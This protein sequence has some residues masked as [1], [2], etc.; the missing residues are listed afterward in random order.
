MLVVEMEENEINHARSGSPPRFSIIIPAFNSGKTIAKCIRSVLAQSFRDFEVIVVDDGSS[1]ETVRIVS[2]FECV[3]LLEQENAGPGCARNRGIKF[4]D[5]D[6]CIFLDSDD[7]WFPD[8]LSIIHSQIEH[9]KEPGLVI[10]SAILNSGQKDL[11]TLERD[12]LLVVEEYLNYYS[13]ADHAISVVGCCFAVKTAQLRMME[14]PFL[15]EPLNAEDLHLLMRLGLVGGFVWIRKPEVLIYN[16]DSN[17]LMSQ[18]LKTIRGINSLLDHEQRGFYPGG[19]GFRK[20][21]WEILT[22]IARSGSLNA[23][24]S[25]DLRLGWALYHRTLFHNVSLRRIKYI[26]VFPCL[27]MFYVCLHT[28]NYLIRIVCRE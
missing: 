7:L 25:G 13:A 26:G 24:K 11:T 5:G 15:P 21:R 19:V 8:A 4:A 6:Y 2:S 17:G 18:T 27:V 3:R 20:A 14:E 1:D 12:R 10:A 23:V 9:G 22:R 28:V 16:T